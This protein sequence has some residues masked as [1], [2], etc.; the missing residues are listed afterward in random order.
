[1]RTGIIAVVERVLVFPAA[2]FITPLTL[3]NLQR[4]NTNPLTAC[5]GSTHIVRITLVAIEREN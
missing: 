5:S 3:G 4:R 1:V 2:L